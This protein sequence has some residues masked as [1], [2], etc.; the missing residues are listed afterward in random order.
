MKRWR[1][2]PQTLEAMSKTWLKWSNLVIR[3]FNILL[4]KFMEHHAPNH[5]VSESLSLFAKGWWF[6]SQFPRSYKT[7]WNIYFA[8]KSVRHRQAVKV[9]CIC[10]T[11]N[12]RS[13]VYEYMSW[14]SSISLKCSLRRQKPYLQTCP[15]NQKVITGQFY[16]MLLHWL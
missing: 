14:I 12:S 2:L 11:W 4:T 6:A 8:M 16:I 13:S 1:Y 7:L 10:M 9:F 3:L 5:L 15:P